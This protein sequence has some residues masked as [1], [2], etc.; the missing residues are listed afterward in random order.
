MPASEIS[1][2]D[3][4]RREN[5]RRILA[6][7]RVSSPQSR[8]ELSAETG[9]SAST[10]TTITSALLERGFLVEAAQGASADAAQQQSRRGRP[11]VALALNPAAATIG[12][13]TVTLN[14]LSVSLI[15][16]SGNVI[17]ETRVRVDTQHLAREAFSGRLATLLQG[18]VDANRSTAGPLSQIV[19]AVQGASDSAGT[20]LQWSPITPHREIAI[21][22]ELQSHFGVPAQVENDANMMAS[23]LHADEPWRFG[24]SFATILLSH[25]I[26]MG[27]YVKDRMFTGI[28]TSAAEF[29]HMCHLPGGSLCRCGR[30]GCIEAYAGDY[31]IWRNATGSS[32]DTVPDQDFDPDTMAGLARRARA[33]DSKAC[34][35]YRMAGEAI[36]HGLRSLFALLDPMPVAFVGSGASAFDLMEPMIRKSLGQRGVGLSYED[37]RLYC[38]P[39][40]FELT[41]RGTIVTALNAL[42]RNLQIVHEA[43]ELE[44]AG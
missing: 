29:G 15:D 30:H 21:G 27:M 17:G 40:D 38:Y 23:A 12:A 8:T 13:V 35:A 19:V 2:S 1:R 11:Q 16:Y 39:N 31:G 34:E 9:L 36:G 44:N 42:D 3:D 37:P 7:L 18:F 28:L 14:Q 10:V 26:G 6:A 43:R 24:D 41:R 4:L 20:S 25:G 5:Q 33:G 22:T 32:A